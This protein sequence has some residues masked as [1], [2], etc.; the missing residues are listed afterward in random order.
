MNAHIAAP[1]ASP[2]MAPARLGA[3]LRS[4]VTDYAVAAT[5][6]CVVVATRVPLAGR[7]LFDW[8][9][10]Q[11][12]LGMQH[13]NLATHRPHPPGYVGYILLGKLLTGPFSGNVNLGLVTLS[14]VAEAFSVAAVFLVARR[15]LGQFAGLAAAVLMLTSPLFWLYGETALTYGLEPGLSLIGFWLIYRAVRAGGKGLVPAA[16][17]LCLAGAIRPS[18]EFFLLPLLCSGIGLTLWNAHRL[19]RL[20]SRRVIDL[21]VLPGCAVVVGTCLWLVPLLYLSGGPAAY[22]YFSGQLAARVSGNSAVWRAGFEGLALNSEAVLAGLALGLG[23]YLALAASILAIALV[24]GLRAGGRRLPR[25]STVL[26]LVW[27]LPAGATF[28][29]VHI[30]QLAYVLFLVPALLLPAGIVLERVAHLV[31]GPWP[32]WR[33]PLRWVLLLACAGAN[34]AT[35][36]LP[37]G[38][39]LSQVQARDR[40]VEALVSLVRRYPPARTVLLADPE[41]PRSYRTAMY[42]LPEYQVIA[43]GRDRRGRAGE[44]FSNRPGAPE[45]DLTRF[46]QVGPLQLP[47]TGTALVLDEALL[48]A[49]GDPNRLRTMT[50]ADPLA[51]HV[52]AVA[53]DPRDPPIARRSWIYLRGSDYPQFRRP[54]RS[55]GDPSQSSCPFASWP[56]ASDRAGS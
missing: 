19:G 31:T 8:D 45:Y 9:S 15:L 47:G 2:L 56:G 26:G 14:I 25:E 20:N 21:A 24:P 10:L 39:L 44:L 43:L 48:A 38:S 12:A 32:G 16:L 18:A 17:M 52:F 13:F 36:A 46:D 23:V 7:Y 34:V 50:I 33:G 42:Y 35:F 29:L 5:F 1:T 55:C 51:R 4:R 6:A 28:L 49:I 27:I 3:L 53:L 41:G 54:L 22:L 11:F 37:E 40:H 30:G